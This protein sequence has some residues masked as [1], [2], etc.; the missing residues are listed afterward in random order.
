MGTNNCSELPFT[1]I[2][3]AWLTTPIEGMLITIS[4]LA[5]PVRRM[6]PVHVTEGGKV[7]GQPVPLTMV[8]DQF[9]YR[10]SPAAWLTVTVCPATVSVPVRASPVFSAIVRFT[11][12]LP[13]WLA[14]EVSVT[15]G[16]FDA[17]VHAQPALADTLR[18]A[19]PPA[20]AML[21]VVLEMVYV[22]VGVGDVG[23]VGEVGVVDS[24]FDEHAPA[25][26]SATTAITHHALRTIPPSIERS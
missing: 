26:T 2:G 11:V 16:A 3:M 13:D 17:A 5:A 25:A 19:V 8:P 23:E 12:P 4:E 9:P 6:V 14:G 10:A 22:Q 21:S 20:P 18:K 15:N 7:A 1:I 24:D